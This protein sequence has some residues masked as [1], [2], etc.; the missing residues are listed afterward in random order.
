MSEMK[1]NLAG[2]H[3]H[4]YSRGRNGIVI[5]IWWLVQGTLFRFSLHPMDGWRRFLLRLFGAHIGHKVKIRPTARITYPWKVEIGD[6]SWVGDEAMLY[7]LDRIIIGSHC[8]VSQKAY[9]CTGSHDI[10]DPHFGLVTQPIHV[11]DGAWVAADVFVHPGVTIHEM[12]VV[13]ARSTVLKD[14]PAHS[15]FAGTPAKYIKK[16]LNS[17]WE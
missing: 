13:A 8:V 10:E 9:L 11:K 3:Q 6:Y 15:V 17:E 14:I 1:V 12:A 16:R 7:S 4:Y 2:Y 5:L